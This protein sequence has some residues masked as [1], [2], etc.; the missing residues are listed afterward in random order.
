MWIL[1]RPSD[2]EQQTPCRRRLLRSRK[3]AYALFEARFPAAGLFCACQRHGVRSYAQKDQ[4]TTLPQDRPEAPRSRSREIRGT[5]QPQFAPFKEKLQVR[6]GAVH[7]LVLLRASTSVEPDRCPAISTLWIFWAWHLE[8]SISALRQSGDWRMKLQI[9]ACS[10][11]N[12]LQAFAESKAQS[13][14]EP[15]RK[16]ANP[17][18]SSTLTG[19]SRRGRSSQCPRSRDDLCARRL[20]IAS[21]RTLCSCR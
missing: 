16:L 5:Q 11:R 6:H 4:K 8:L 7:R 9:P 3:I 20:R 12:S 1:L 17:G 21:G 14:L 18:P 19:E 13:N 10:V 2:E 15:L